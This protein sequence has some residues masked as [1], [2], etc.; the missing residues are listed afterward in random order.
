MANPS[1]LDSGSQDREPFDAEHHRQRGKGNA[2]GGRA[3]F[4][5]RNCPRDARDEPPG[6][7]WTEDGRCGNQ[8]PPN[9]WIVHGEPRH[10]RHD[11]HPKA[12]SEARGQRQCGRGIVVQAK[13]TEQARR[14]QKQCHR[15]YRQR[16]GRDGG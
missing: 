8:R 13:S 9:R 16:A 4:D 1:A 7:P 14:K 15:K 12:D 6:S 11:E 5:V 10:D 2:F 3:Q